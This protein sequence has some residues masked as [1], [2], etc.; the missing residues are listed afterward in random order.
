[1]LSCENIYV[2]I[3]GFQNIVLKVFHFCILW[4][5]R[6]SKLIKSNFTTK[7]YPQ[8]YT[9]LYFAILLSMTIQT[10]ESLISRQ[11]EVYQNK[12]ANHG[13]LEGDNWKFITSKGVSFSECS[14]SKVYF[15]QFQF[16]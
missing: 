2:V 10:S 12:R 6:L 13:M 4:M 15:S 1:M 11:Y 7:M 14:V 5:P 8:G 3:L 16:I 9:A